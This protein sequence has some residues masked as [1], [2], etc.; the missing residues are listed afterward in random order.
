MRLSH[1]IVLVVRNSGCSAEADATASALPSTSASA[2]AS[3]AEPD[4]T[5][6]P[7]LDGMVTAK[8]PL[9]AAF[10]GRYTS[11]T[12]DGVWIPNGNEGKGA[13]VARLDPSTLE[14]A[15]V[16]D[17][18][19]EA[20]AFP[21]DAEATAPSANGIWVT[22]AYQDA[23]ALVDPRTNAESRRITVEGDAYSLVEDGESLWIVDYGGSVVR[24]DIA[25][26]E[27][28][29][30]VRSVA[31]PTGVAISAGS[32]WVADHDT[33][34]VIRLDPETGDEL[35]RI[36]VGGRPGIA[37]G[38]GSVWARSDDERT[39]SRIDPAT[40]GVVATIPM[41]MN[42]SDIE[43]AGDSVWVVASPQRGECERNSYLVRIDPATNQA[44]GMMGLPCATML[45]TDGRG[46]W[47]GSMEGDEISILRLDPVARQ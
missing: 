13:A 14:V 9:T 46:L 24:I 43:V 18:G 35:A 41:P 37:I 5:A 45:A 26:G 6:L 42:A 44:D 47:A 36:Q 27:E 20:G 11:V 29:L 28:R 39:V 32:I 40:N 21:P 33:G 23:V 17:L 38:F 31:G 19:G 30:R 8:A 34:N 3:P 12:A 22:L 15:A 25:T 4:W 10:P 7:A 1:A 2:S 16:V